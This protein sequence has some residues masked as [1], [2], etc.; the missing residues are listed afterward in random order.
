M[1]RE[2]YPNGNGCQQ[3][4]LPAPQYEMEGLILPPTGMAGIGGIFTYGG[5]FL[6]YNVFG[7][8]F[9]V[10]AKYKPPVKPISGGAYGV[11][12]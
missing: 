3:Q 11:V 2:M 10:A 7:H 12:W 4:F 8:L 1:Y 5:S 9:E 6:Q